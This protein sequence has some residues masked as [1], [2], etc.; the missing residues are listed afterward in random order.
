[1]D[2]NFKISPKQSK[3]INSTAFET[4]FGGAA[5]G[6]KSYGQLL[7]A[8][9]YA[10]QYPKSKQA[11]FRRTCPELEKSIIPTALS[12]YPAKLY[13][14]NASKHEMTFINGSIIYF[15]YCDSY[16]DTAKY[17]SAEFDVIR[18]DELTHFPEE[19]YIYLI[20]RVR[21][22]NGFPKYVKSST[23]PGGV[24]HTW[25]KQR[26]IDIGA[27]NE[28]HNVKYGEGV[29]K[30]RTFIPSLVT[31]N[32][33]LL[34]ADPEYVSR[35]QMLPEIEKQRL[36]YGN[37]DIMAGQ[38]FSEFDRSIHVIEPFDIPKEW[39]RYAAID[40]GLDC[41]AVV[42]AAFD[43]EGNTYIYRDCA[44]PNLIISEASEQIKK[45]TDGE[46]I[47]CV[48]AP[49]DLWSRSQESGQNRAELF[50]KNGV[51]LIKSNNDRRAGWAVIKEALTLNGVGHE[52]KLKI[53]S[54]CVNL[55]ESLPA[56]LV[57]E[58]DFDDCSTEPHKY[59]HVPDALR[60][61]MVMHLSKPAVPKKEMSITQ[62]D[63]MRRSRQARI[64]M[65]KGGMY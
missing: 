1:M 61:L 53:F 27:P 45:M 15:C 39:R 19:I 31:D 24:G 22:V 59:T 46:N 49:P 57:D 51:P 25:V 47:R 34:N 7:D 55:I 2:I 23:N 40:Y 54:N 26:F 8:L 28:I 5:G 36:L 12:S 29:Y 64:A 3:F 44:M 35:L 50:A 38:F 4:L 58:H 48:Y 30:T 32:S 18:F 65:K 9:R 41:L 33:F 13:K 10:L 52:P 17:Q 20:S 60:Y 16:S 21:G 6:G 37:W 43:F 62:R 63:K 42:A 11:I 56:L 14:Y